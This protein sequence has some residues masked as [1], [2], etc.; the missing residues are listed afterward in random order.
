MPMKVAIPTEVN[1]KAFPNSPGGLISPGDNSTVYEPDRYPAQLCTR[2]HP[3]PSC[4]A[5]SHLSPALSCKT[6]PIKYSVPKKA[7][8]GIGLYFLEHVRL[9]LLKHV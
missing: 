1:R 5:V 9:L 7:R 6:Q 8:Q 4:L 3:L 2:L